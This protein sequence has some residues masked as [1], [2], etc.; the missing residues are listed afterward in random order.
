[1]ISTNLSMGPAGLLDLD[2]ERVHFNAS[3][4]PEST[5]LGEFLPKVLALKSRG[6]EPGVAL[7]AWPPFLDRLEEYRRAFVSSGVPFSLMVFQGRHAGKDYPA[8]YTALERSILAGCIKDECEK[9]YRMELKGTLGKPCHAGRVYANV[10]G[11]GAVYRCGQDA[12]SRKPL[13][14]IFDPGFKLH[15]SVRPCPYEHCSCQ[16]FEYLEEVMRACTR[17]AGS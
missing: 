9:S 7:V 17:P 16:E 14:N 5:E 1:V 2:P 13:G 4:H 15:A 10:K 3:F 11:D 6:F 12:F 8:A